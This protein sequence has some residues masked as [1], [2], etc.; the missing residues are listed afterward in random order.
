MIEEHAI[1]S[2]EQWQALRAKDVTASVVGALFGVHPYLT[3]GQLYA[4]KKQLM[5]TVAANAVIRRGIRLENLVAQEVGALHP[6]WVIN[7]ATSYF[8][9]PD[10]RLGATPDFFINPD[11]E[12]QRGILQVKTAGVSAYKRQWQ[13]GPPLWILLQVATEMHLTNSQWGTIAVLPVGEWSDFSVETYHVERHQGVIDRIIDA[14]KMFWH[15]FNHDAMPTIDYARDNE[16]VKLLYPVEVAGKTIDLTGDNRIKEL[17]NERQTVR[18]ALK[19]TEQ[20]RDALETEIK[21]KIGDAERAIVPGWN[22]TLK[23][24]HRKAYTVKES[25]SRRLNIKQIGGDDEAANE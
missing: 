15:A 7:K 10:L 2:P 25:S 8:R 24:Q 11:S 22:V 19:T 3:I 16:L 9:D 14:T 5:S 23:L 6:D 17:L 1:T 4:Q 20:V 21:C 12:D 13:E 18:A